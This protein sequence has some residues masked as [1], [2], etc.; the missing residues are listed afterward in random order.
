MNNN[1]WMTTHI[2]AQ[3]NKKGK[4]RKKNQVKSNS[5]RNDLNFVIFENP[6]K[7]VFCI[8]VR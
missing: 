3:K 5:I 1:E 4:K 2:H 7:N 6:G 8:F